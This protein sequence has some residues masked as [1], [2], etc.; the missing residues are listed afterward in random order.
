MYFLASSVTHVLSILVVQDF[1]SAEHLLTHH[2]NIELQVSL[3]ERD[4]LYSLVSAMLLHEAA[5]DVQYVIKL[6]Q[7]RSEPTCS[8]CAWVFALHMSRH[9]REGSYCLSGNAFASSLL[10]TSVSDFS[11]QPDSL[12]ADK[13]H[14]S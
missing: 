9:A 5:F 12:S 13:S 6:T 7:Y 3:L 14:V 11:I 2:A 1:T 10:I 8:A 4:S